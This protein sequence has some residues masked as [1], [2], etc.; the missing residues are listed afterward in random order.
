MSKPRIRVKGFEE[1]WKE[2][3]AG[4]I[5]KSI[6]DKG[7][8]ELPVLS[9]T[10]DR[11]MVIRDE[12]DK[13][14]IHDTNNESDYKRV[15]PGQFVIHLRS[16]QGGF[17]HS[18]VEGITSPAYTVMG[19]IESEKHDDY[20]WKYVFSS[21]EFINRL[22]TVTYGIRDGRSISYND[23][24]QMKFKYPSREEQNEIAI[25]IKDFN[26][27][28]HKAQDEITRLNSLKICY[29]TRLF[30]IG[31]GYRTPYENARIHR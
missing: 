12:I 17:A 24:L 18:A 30:P 6:S 15:I 8:S 13:V 29:L 26:A 22:K 20:F 25:T 28:L 23:F 10:Q 2:I 21:K 3:D 4:H 31:G 9:A 27:L 14:V 1:D 11:G 7:H 5:F 19:F 16:F